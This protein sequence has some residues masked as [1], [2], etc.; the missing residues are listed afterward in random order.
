MVTLRSS[1]VQKIESESEEEREEDDDEQDDN[2]E[3]DQS[4]SE[5]GKDQENG[6]DSDSD[7]APQEESFSGSKQ[8]AAQ[9]RN[10]ETTARKQAQQAEKNRRR[11]MVDGKQ[12]QAEKNK[13]TKAVTS[14]GM[15]DPSL[16]MELE[17]A[18]IQKKDVQIQKQ[19]QVKSQVVKL[20]EKKRKRVV[21]G[22]VT[23]EVSNKQTNYGLSLLPTEQDEQVDE[24][25]QS[26]KKKNKKNKQPKKVLS[27][28]LVPVDLTEFRQAHLFGGRV[29]RVGVEGVIDK[30]RVRC[31]Q[32]ARVFTT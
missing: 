9:A 15:F 11:K 23:L 17:E 5:G 20:A 16:L 26:N 27:H 10:Q 2:N 29:Q 7:D 18:D 6:D 22:N 30:S 12:K 32:P 4:E 21:V 19:K 3:D 24:A 14:D 31:H 8:Q 28:T 1:K 25:D 13:A